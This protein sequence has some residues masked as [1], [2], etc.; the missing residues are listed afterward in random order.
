ML[1][2]LPALA[3]ARASVVLAYAGEVATAQDTIRVRASNAPAWGSDP[4]LV[5]ELT[6]GALDGPPE[7]AL[8]RIQRIAAEPG[9]AFYV[10]DDGDTQIRRYDARGY[11]R[12]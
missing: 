11:L 2:A 4:A 9:G 5:H 7:Y 1:R 10:Y 8:G 6:V 3:L 12:P